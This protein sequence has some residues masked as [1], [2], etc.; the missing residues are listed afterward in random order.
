M[1][2]NAD[3][4]ADCRG[5]SHESF[6]LFSTFYLLLYVHGYFAHMCLRT[7]WVPGTPEVEE[8][9]RSH[10]TRIMDDA[11]RVLDLKP[12]SSEKAASILNHWAISPTPVT[13]FKKF[14]SMLGEARVPSTSLEQSCTWLSMVHGTQTCPCKGRYCSFLN[15][16]VQDN[17][18]SLSVTNIH[19]EPHTYRSLHLAEHKPCQPTA[20]VS[21]RLKVHCC[22]ATGAWHRDDAKSCK[23]ILRTICDLIRL[24]CSR[25]GLAAARRTAWCGTK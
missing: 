20:A 7:P 18:W 21:T 24:L 16:G 2:V 10:G 12:L 25:A 17:W 9:V 4:W 8:S 19:R 13:H 22:A 23:T 6:V 15:T 5:F 3:A 14:L 1:F 11:I